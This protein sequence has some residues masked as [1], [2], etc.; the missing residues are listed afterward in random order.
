MI[1]YKAK[2]QEYGRRFPPIRRILHKSRETHV[3]FK[4]EKPGKICKI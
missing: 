4:E 1:G 3:Y 2:K